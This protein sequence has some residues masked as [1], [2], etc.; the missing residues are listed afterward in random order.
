MPLA[1]IAAALLHML[2]RLAAE[3]RDAGHL[4]ASEAMGVGVDVCARA[5]YRLA[6]ALAAMGDAD[7]AARAEA[8]GDA[9]SR[10]T[11]AVEIEEMSAAWSR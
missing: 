10:W 8:H 9:L 7:G 2:A 3:H 11:A 4:D 5:L 6:D 1:A